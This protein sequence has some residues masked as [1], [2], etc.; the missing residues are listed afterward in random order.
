MNHFAV[1]GRLRV[2][3]TPGEG[4]PLV[5]TLRP[6]TPVSV[7]GPTGVRPVGGITWSVT[8]VP[9]LGPA[10]RNGGR[11]LALELYDPHVAERVRGQA[12]REQRLAADYTTPVAVAFAHFGPQRRGLRGFLARTTDFSSTG[13]YLTA[14]ATPD[15]TPVVLVHGL[16][17][18]PTDFHDLQNAFDGVPGLRR[19]YQVWFFYYPTSLSVPYSAML[20]REDLAL[21]IHQLDPQGSHPALH[22]AVLVGHSM[23]GLLCR[24][25]VS[26]GGDRYYHHF[27]KPPLD[28]LRLT[29]EQRDLVRR[30]FYYRASPDVAQVVFIATPHHGS[31]LANGVLGTIG[32]WLVRI[33]AAV[34]TRVQD[35][36]SR[37]RAVLVAPGT[38]KRAS[39]LTSL[40]PRDPLIVAVNDA[41]IRPGVRLHSILGDRGRGGPRERSSD[42]VVPYASAHLP[43]AASE[44]IVPGGHVGTLKR[45]ETA[46][47]IIR[48]L[49]SADKIRRTE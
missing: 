5:A 9:V 43:Q 39:S 28:N 26:D 4:V 8:A 37:N 10:A 29:N 16:L 15:K 46:D 21:I 35:I 12:G 11:S 48:I 3:R 30:G 32:R 22:R 13:L 44:R 27:F 17:S 23:G 25:M 20:L 18:D 36:I 24:L 47:E 34:R 45:P 41:R 14:K 1:A 2:N 49:L 6:F 7:P 31:K 33:P 42:G 19:R 38:S 40:S